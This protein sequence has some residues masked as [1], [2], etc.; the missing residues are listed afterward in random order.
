MLGPG[1]VAVTAFSLNETVYAKEQ[2]K[3]DLAKIREAILE[4]IENDQEKRGDG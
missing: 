1:A 2:P 3:N 4:V